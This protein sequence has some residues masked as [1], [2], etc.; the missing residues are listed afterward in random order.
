MYRLWLQEEGSGPQIVLP[1]KSERKSLLQHIKMFNRIAI[2][3]VTKL[4]RACHCSLHTSRMKVVKVLFTSY[5]L[6]T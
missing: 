3:P 1:L 4:F 5:L 6:S 2:I